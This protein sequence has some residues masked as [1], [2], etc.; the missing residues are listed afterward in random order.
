MAPATKATIKITA[1]MISGIAADH[2]HAGS[3]LVRT[4]SGSGSMAS[5]IVYRLFG[6]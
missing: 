6:H 4:C 2:T 3:V 5:G 1:A